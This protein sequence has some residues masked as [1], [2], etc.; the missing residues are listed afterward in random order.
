MKTDW[1]K[2]KIFIRMKRCTSMLSPYEHK[3]LLYQVFI[4]NKFSSVHG[5]NY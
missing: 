3:S 1:I 2:P 5:E 4:W